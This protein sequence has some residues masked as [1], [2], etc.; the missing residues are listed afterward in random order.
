M[1][2]PKERQTW[3][4]EVDVDSSRE[5][6]REPREDDEWDA[7]CTQTE[8]TINGL[9]LLDGEGGYR[10]AEVL[11]KPVKGE[12]Y[13][14]LYAV[15]STGDSFGHYAGAGFE[16]IGV[17]K[18][19]KVAELNRTRLLEGK[20]VASRKS[21]SFELI[22]LRVEGTKTTHNYFRPWLGYFESL[23]KLEIDS[24]VLG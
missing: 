14:L 7:G 8:H 17:Y 1:A 12:T 19:R 18:D 24:F 3:Y 4:I 15:Y 22:R 5:Y 6:T 16:G 13:H 21:F 10:S 23:D 11:I 20:P 9:R 2:K